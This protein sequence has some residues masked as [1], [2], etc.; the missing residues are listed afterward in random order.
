MCGKIFPLFPWAKHRTTLNDKGKKET[1]RVTNPFHPLYNQEFELVKCRNNWG[2]RRVY[3]LDKQ[4]QMAS[5]CASWTDVDELDPFVK[6]SN[7]RAVATPTALLDLARLLADIKKQ[8][9]K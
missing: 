3:F 2:D 9:V 5:V 6:Q 8:S 7:Q 4:G 1:F